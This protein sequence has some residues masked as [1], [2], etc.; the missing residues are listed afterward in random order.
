[1][2]AFQIIAAEKGKMALAEHEVSSPARGEIQVRACSSLISPGTERAF[3]LTLENTDTRFP[4]R[5]GYCCAGVVTKA[6]EGAAFAVGDRVAGDMQHVSLAN[7]PCEN[8]ALVPDNVGDDEA[9]FTRIGIIAMQ[10]VRKARIELGEAVL[11][12]GAGLVGQIAL[13]LARANGAYPVICIDKVASKR[14][15]AKKLGADIAV[16]P[17]DAD[18][19]EQVRAATGGEGAPVVIECTGFPQPIANALLAAKKFGR[20]VI[21]GSTRG[22]TEVNF[23]RDVHK[24]A[25]TIVGAHI[26]SNP[27]KESY[28]GYWTAQD[29]AA[30]F[31]NLMK[32]GRIQMKPLISEKRPFTEC[33]AIYSSVLGWEKEYITTVIDW[34]NAE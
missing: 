32:T 15:L 29:N 33:E 21:L 13:Q 34:S 22:C 8:M 23:Y 17:G 26:S 1:M 24:K 3:I 30:A 31:L 27:D 25:L 7:V 11:V 2:K 14:E 20:V 16:D 4:Y 9:A 12:I 6:G 19:L 18:W 10:A 28:P 5:P